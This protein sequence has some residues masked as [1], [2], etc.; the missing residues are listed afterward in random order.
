[1]LRI[2]RQ[3]FIQRGRILALFYALPHQVYILADKS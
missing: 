1:M 3:D 2:K